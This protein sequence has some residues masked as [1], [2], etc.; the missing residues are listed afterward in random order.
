MTDIK[1]KILKTTKFLIILSLIFIIYLLYLQVVKAEDFSRNSI[2]LRNTIFKNN[3]I[4]GTIFD[5]ENRPLAKNNDE[6]IRIYPMG[7]SAA[8]IVGYANPNIGNSGIENYFN[9]E[10]LGSTE[11]F[12]N[13]GYIAQIFNCKKGNNLILTLDSDVMQTAYYALEG[14]PGAVVVIDAKTGGVIAMVS[15]PSFNPNVIQSEWQVL[16][17]NPESP[18]MNRAANGL[19]PPGSIIKPMM[20]DI[21]L[22]N[23]IT[24]EH[25]IFECG[26]EIDV[27]KGYTIKEAHNDTHGHLH[28]KE[29]LVKSCNITFGTLAMRLGSEKLESGFERY[30]FYEP[31]RG[32]IF[33]TASLIPNF[34]S[35]DK[36]DMAQIGIGQ[37]SLLV[38]PLRMALIASAIA[39]DG[40][41]AEPYVLEKII[42]P[43]GYVL[44]EHKKKELLRIMSKE[45]AELLSD[46]MEEVVISGTGKAA[47]VSGIKIAGKTGTAENAKDKEHSW[48]M[49]FAEIGERKV[50]FSV[51]VENGGSGADVAAPIAKKI[52]LN[53]EK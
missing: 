12:K 28:L 32:E 8:H 31:I 46:W 20:A 16:N 44:K 40:V 39:N 6:N 41:L 24:D 4:R 49:G 15:S 14:K 42:S 7:E 34:K 35:L 26:G 23:A 11:D 51:L 30:G 38:T 33:E 13:M 36:G 9:N 48:F 47:K 45:R 17:E 18:L 19:Y 5:C 25:E 1:Q 2:N 3:N 53:M 27:G 29:A 21:A 22:S 37:S 52:I 10:L 50:A 43:S